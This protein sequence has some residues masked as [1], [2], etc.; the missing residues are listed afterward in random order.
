MRRVVHVHRAIDDAQKAVRTCMLPPNGAHGPLGEQHTSAHAPAQA[1]L[2]N[3]CHSRQQQQATAQPARRASHTGAVALGAPLS[4]EKLAADFCVLQERVV[5][6][7]LLPGRVE[8]VLQQSSAVS[9]G[10]GGR[11][12]H[13]RC[14]TCR[15]RTPQL[16]QCRNAIRSGNKRAV[17]P[18]DSSKRHAGIPGD[19]GKCRV[20]ALRTRSYLFSGAPSFQRFSM[21]GFASA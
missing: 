9:P 20:S 11:A 14:L 2:R 4:A 12:A 18:G 6:V 3:T 5:D 16:V 17:I 8:R 15:P 7:T 10:L 19:S 21:S 1:P 13:T